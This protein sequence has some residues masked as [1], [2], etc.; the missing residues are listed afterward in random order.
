VREGGRVAL[1]AALL[2]VDARIEVDVGRAA[3]LAAEAQFLL[4]GH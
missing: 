1:E 3:D 2:A 4:P